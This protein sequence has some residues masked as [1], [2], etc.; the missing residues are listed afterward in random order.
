MK[1]RTESRV[2]ARRPNAR[3]W[4]GTVLEAAIVLPIL[5]SLTFGAIEFGD[6]FFVKHT[7]EAAA[8][9]GARNGITDTATN[10][11]VGTAVTAVITAAGGTNW[12]AVTAITDTS[13]NAVNVATVT[14]GNS[15][16]VQ[17]SCTWGVCGLRPM[18]L[19]GAA[20]Q[21]IGSCVMR[22]ES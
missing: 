16:K 12:G 14:A 20:K 5:I 11:T 4:G 6:Y 3:R 13:N 8:R 19:I 10:T 7:L 21:V 18:Q 17:V 15:I 2:L 22:K 1:D 9:E